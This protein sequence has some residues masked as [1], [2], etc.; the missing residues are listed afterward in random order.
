MSAL[1]LIRRPEHERQS[2]MSELVQYQNSNDIYGDICQIVDSSQITAYKS[3]NEILVI[4][5]WLIGRRISEEEL[6]GSDRAE[7]GK[8]IIESLA[9]TLTEKYGKGFTKRNL[10]KYQQF[11]R[12]F[13]EIMPSLMAQS[14]GRGIVLS[15]TAQLLS[16]THYERL[17]QVA[18]PEA[19]D[20]YASEAYDQSWSVRTLQRNISSQYYYRMLKT[21]D[22]YRERRLLYRSC[23]L[24]LYIKVLCPD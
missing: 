9:V 13:P 22:P 10:Y 1:A 19:R 17:L 11:Y 21:Q 14:E 8:K 15:P 5:N 2:I 24:Q 16:W 7:Y 20:W 4:R 18:D 12:Y 23:F 3:V 6:K